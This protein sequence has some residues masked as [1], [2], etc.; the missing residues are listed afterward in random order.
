ML[1]VDNPTTRILLV[2]GH[3]MVR[4]G[5]R[6]ILE[7]KFE[8]SVVGDTGDGKDAIEIA[9][10]E[11]PEIILIDPTP[12]C[13][14]T[15]GLFAG[16]LGVANNTRIIMLTIVP[17][18]TLYGQAINLGAMG[19]VSKTA[20]S[21][22]LI[23]AIDRVNAGEIWLEGSVATRT[24]VEL[25]ANCKN[26]DGDAANIA[27]LTRREREVAALVAKALKNKQI[28]QRLFI[29]EATVSHHLTSIFNKLGISNR[30]QLIIYALSHRLN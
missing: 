15:C 20:T 13:D 26:V 10:R 16:L 14:E 8:F 1:K 11:Q 24:I 9:R 2:D 25:L 18:S 30:S 19:V 3:A 23:K 5:V 12:I 29:S 6:L 28:A 21:E 4:E 17:D 22:V 7:S 27:R